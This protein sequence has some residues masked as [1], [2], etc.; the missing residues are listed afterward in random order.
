[1][2]S[3]EGERVQ[4]VL[5]RAGLGSRRA[6]EE[7]IVQGRV[8]VNGRRIALGMRIE[9][10]KD[11]VEVD[12]S[13]IPVQPNNVYILLNKPRGVVSTTSD[14][15]GRATATG[16]VDLPVR[17]WPVGRLDVDTEG[18]LVLTNDGELTNRLTHPRHA[19][20]KTYLAEVRGEIGA[21]A[22]KSLARGVVLEDGVTAPARAA[23]IER[24]GGASI[25]ELSI[26]EG[27]NRQV[28]RMF[29]AVGHPVTRLVRVAIG[30]LK[31]GRLKPG[32]FRKLAPQEVFALYRATSGNVD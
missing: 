5:A 30:P 31:L 24:S 26:A 4:K 12:G 22:I 18:A 10:S 20:V 17:I 32:S 14:P 21:R 7:L 23:L 1:M 15:E 2:T 28:R 13:P 27:R 16:L 29:E 3:G 9:P 19:V 11:L 8:R 25:V 6:V